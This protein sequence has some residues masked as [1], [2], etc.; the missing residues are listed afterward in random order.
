ML[1]WEET[2][3]NGNIPKLTDNISNVSRSDG[4]YDIYWDY[5]DIEE[6]EAVIQKIIK[7]FDGEY[8]FSIRFYEMWYEWSFSGDINGTHRD[9]EVG[10]VPVYSP[11]YDNGHQIYIAFK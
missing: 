8:E 10:Y 5:M 7:S 2:I 6:S 9:I 4:C 11:D 1:K 3:L